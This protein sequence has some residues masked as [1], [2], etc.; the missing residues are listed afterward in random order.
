M[1]LHE[2][3]GQTIAGEAAQWLYELDYN[4]SCY[5]SNL[6]DMRKFLDNMHLS[7]P[8]KDANPEISRKIK[9]IAHY[10]ENIAMDHL[11]KE[12]D[13]SWQYELGRKEISIPKEP[14]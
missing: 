1:T 11:R 3:I 4:Y 7:G 5:L 12:A 8:Y 10:L 6:S 2:K 13:N 9:D 14:R